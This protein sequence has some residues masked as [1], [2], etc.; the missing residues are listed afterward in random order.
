MKVRSTALAD[1][2]LIEPRV[3]GDA[4][5]FFLETFHRERFASL[6]LPVDFVQDNHS[7]SHR[8]VLRGLHYQL[9]QPQGKLIRVARGEIYDVVVDIR[10]GSPTFAQWIG[11][12]LS[13]ENQQLLWIPPGFAHGFYVVTEVADVTYKCTALYAPDDERGLLWSDPDLAIA[14]PSMTPLLSSK[15]RA[16]LPLS[17]NAELPVYQR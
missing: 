7:R 14:W 8:G 6:G 1:V 10:R 4:R 2:K 13:D 5:G 17:A 16:Y 3:F 11:V 9:H 12:T 15:D